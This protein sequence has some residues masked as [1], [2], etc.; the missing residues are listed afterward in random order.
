MRGIIIEKKWHSAIVM[1]ND[2]RFRRLYLPFGKEV[3]DEVVLERQ[4]RMQF[5]VAAMAVIFLMAGV[6]GLNTRFQGTAY[7]FVSIEINPAAEFQINRYGVVVEAHPLNQKAEQVLGEISFRWRAIERVAADYVAQALAAGLIDHPDQARILVTISGIEGADEARLTQRLEAIQ[8]AQAARLAQMA[9]EAETDYRQVTNETRQEA[10][11]LGIATGTWERIR[12]NEEIPFLLFDLE[13]EAENEELEVYYRKLAHGFEAEL[14]W[15]GRGRDLELEGAR[16]I[17]TLLPIFRSLELHQHMS[18]EEIIQRV[19]TAFGWSVEVEEFSLEAR[20]VDGSTIVFE[21][22]GVDATQV[23]VRETEPDD[24]DDD[25]W[26]DDNDSSVSEA[27][28]QPQP[29]ATAEALSI[30]MF[31]LFELEIEGDDGN[32]D[33]ELEVTYRRHPSGSSE[34]EVEFEQDDRKILDLEGQAAV[35][36]LLP[37]FRQMALQPG[38]SRQQVVDRVI[39]AFGWQGS[40]EEFQLEV[41]F[42]NGERISFAID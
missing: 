7:G 36:Y 22:S 27:P 34:A 40:F 26:D 14:E 32:D 13:I 20:L 37:R 1:T 35:D 5:A 39:S 16:A 24:D 17:E 23:P 18:Q 9:V 3:A 30:V 21:A 15:E 12:Q 8:T 33:D 38:M 19:T 29:T 6:V 2:G 25:D 41:I 10:I 11:S 4:P 28:W 31:E 42:E